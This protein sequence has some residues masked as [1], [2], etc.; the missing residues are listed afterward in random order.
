MNSLI[1]LVDSVLITVDVQD[2]FLGKLPEKQRE[3]LSGLIGWLVEVAVRLQVPLIVTAEDMPR[4]GGMTPVIAQLLPRQTTQFNKMTFNLAA[5]PEIMAALTATGRQTVVL[6]G[7]ETDVCVAQSALGL[8]Q[9][10]YQVVALADATGSP[11]L[12]HQAGLD[13]MRQAGVLIATVKSL[14]YEWVRTVAGHEAFM[15]QYGR[16][17]DQ[18][19]GLDL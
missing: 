14:Y 2:H 8:L 12:A 15:A 3:L 1:S 17:I 9:A 11:G 7:L 10:G 5:E 18:P 6:V 16:E 4:L 19:A 13:R